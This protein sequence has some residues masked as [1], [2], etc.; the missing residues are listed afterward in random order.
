MLSNVQAEILFVLNLICSQS[1]SQI[2]NANFCSS[3]TAL[4]SLLLNEIR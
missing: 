1:Y 4:K 3:I 2:E